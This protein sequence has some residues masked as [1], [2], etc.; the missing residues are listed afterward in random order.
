MRGGVSRRELHRADQALWGAHGW[1][2]NE[3]GMLSIQIYSLIFPEW[4]TC[5]RWGFQKG[6]S[7][8][9]SRPMGSVMAGGK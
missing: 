7:Q 6:T 8:G 5:A 3:A 1:G 2:G 9:R 4:R